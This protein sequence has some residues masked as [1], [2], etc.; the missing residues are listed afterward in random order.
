MILYRRIVYKENDCRK[1]RLQQS[2]LV[3][4]KFVFSAVAV[5]PYFVRGKG[6]RE[7]V[8]LDVVAKQKFKVFIG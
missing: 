8:R 2:F 5:Y 4:K 7:A 1:N 6:G 3:I